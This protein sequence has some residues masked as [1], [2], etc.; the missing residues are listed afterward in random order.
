MKIRP[1]TPAHAPAILSIL[2]A[3]FIIISA[4][5]AFT[6]SR[7]KALLSDPAGRGRLEALAQLEETR[8]IT[9]Y[10]IEPLI[11]DPNTLIRLR[12]AEVLGRI[13]STEGIPYLEKLT[14]D[15]NAEVVESALFSLGLIGDDTAVEVI[16]RCLKGKPE[17]IK[18]CALRAMRISR[19][20]S[21]VQMVLPFLKDFHGS[22]RA[23]AAYAVALLGDSTAAA[24]CVNSLHDPDTATIAGALYALGRLGYRGSVGE[25]ARLLRHDEADV[26][27]RACEAL[28]RLDAKEAVIPVAA[29]LRDPERMVTVKAIEALLRIADKKGTDALEQILTSEDV[30]LRAQAL[31]ALA[32]IGMS[33]SF[34]AVTPL[35]EDRS[36]MVR[37][38]AIEAVAATGGKNA[39][40]HLLRIAG[41]GLPVERMAALRQLGKQGNRDDLPLLV[42]TLLAGS[43]LFQR[44]GAADG[45][46]RWKEPGCLT[47]LVTL[48]ERKLS[49]LEALLEASDG[50]DWVVASIATEALG[51][52]GTAG[53]IPGMLRISRKHDSRVDSDRKLGIIKAVTAIGT[54]NA[55]DPP[56]RTAAE[57]L[58]RMAGNDPDPRVSSAAVSAANEFGLEILAQPAGSWN[59]G[60]LP[61]GEPALPLGNRKILITTDRG[62]I[63]IVLYGDDAPN[64]VRSIITLAGQEFYD[65]LTF[66]RVVPGFVIQGGCPR[67]DGWG[68][69]GY[70]L[71]SQFN[72]IPYERGTV[73][74]AH[75][76]KDTPGSQFFITHTPQPHLD[77]RYTVVGKVTRGMEVV[78]VIEAGDTFAVTVIE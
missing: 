38:S 26:R 64:I 16:G 58:F 7:Y 37:L 28:G 57:S 42:E 40:Q 3:I 18:L 77:G 33:G 73:G 27:L 10:V 66:H 48:S 61:W 13:G 47:D 56:E 21:A 51:R 24:E 22:L 60:V 68:D 78:D 25:M 70:F 50:E 4:G 62:E 19:N 31:R 69:A 35:L 9:P 1:H 49:P 11:V 34:D 76:G 72:T 6:E 71:R 30:Y 75:A 46:G 41:E 74:M 67:G 12:C 59:R 2:A 29:L 39:R 23:E 65:G 36:L 17:A 44:E 43:D 5:P 45:L 20:S 55:I 8:T 32:E 14:G 54:R 15:Q 53:T 52:V 63:E